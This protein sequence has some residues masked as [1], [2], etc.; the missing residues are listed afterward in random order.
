M[1]LRGQ[2]AA[3]TLAMFASTLEIA[4]EVGD[5]ML[6]AWCRIWL[7]RPSS[8]D[9]HMTSERAA[10]LERVIDDARR[11]GVRHPIG[12][13]CSIL[14]QYALE[15]GDY[16]RARRF[17]D[18]AVATYRELDDQ[19]QLVQQ[20]I[21]RAN[22]GLAVND[23]ISTALD[24]VE[25]TE[26]ALEI[27]EDQSLAWAADVL[28][29]YALRTHEDGIAESLA[30]AYYACLDRFEDAGGGWLRIYG[31]PRPDHASIVSARPLAEVCRSALTEMF[32]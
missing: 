19:Y 6:I 26:L 7:A 27:G 4:R 18:E 1:A 21:A 32:N 15:E 20:L 5:P 30:S 17:F 13:A 3:E 25:G 12:E 10:E 23:L 9:H 8:R 14:G 22:T 16:G 28:Y 11:S 29:N 24:V 31:P 2:P